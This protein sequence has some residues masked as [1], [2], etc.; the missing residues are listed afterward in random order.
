MAVQLYWT[1]LSQLQEWRTQLCT[2]SEKERHFFFF[3]LQLVNSV[4]DIST[5]RLLF[6]VL[7]QI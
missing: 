1:W 7:G 6:V 4:L 5:S 2:F 3:F